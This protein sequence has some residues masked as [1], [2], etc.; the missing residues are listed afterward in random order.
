M[1]PIGHFLHLSSMSPSAVIVAT[2][3]PDFGKLLGLTHQMLGYSIADAVDASRKQHHDIARFL[4]CL[5][6]F[7]DRDAKVD[8]TP[9]LLRFCS[10][11]VLL[12]ADEEDILGIV[13]A[14]GMPFVVAETIKRGVF[15]A[16]CTGTLD[17][18]KDAVVTGSQSKLQVVR[19]C[20]GKIMGLFE[21]IQISLWK[22]FSVKTLND[23]TLR[24]EDKRG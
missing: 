6:A 3:V 23:R 13:Q 1:V 20:F 22:E 24:L 18:W 15:T 11:S 12:A 7:K 21:A 9:D 8:P 16:I 14:A 10:V 19:E 17:Q 2:T 5:A 4:A